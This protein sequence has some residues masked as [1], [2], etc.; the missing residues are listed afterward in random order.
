MTSKCAG[1]LQNLP[2][3]E[4]LTCSLCKSSYDLDCANV[5]IVRFNNTMSAEHK[6]N[7]KCQACY[8]KMPK[9]GNTNTPVRIQNGPQPQRSPNAG[10]N[11]TMRRK[12]TTS[13]YDTTMVYDD[14][15]SIL[16]NTCMENNS[17]NNSCQIDSLLLT[18]IE[19]LLEKKL[20]NNK[21]TLLSELKTMLIQEISASVT[22]EIALNINTISTEQHTM[23]T[24]INQLNTQIKSL[25]I[26]TNRLQI[27]INELQ[28]KMTLQTNEQ[29][30]WLYNFENNRKFV[31]YG[32]NE[33]YWETE[34]ELHNRVTYIF[35]DLL[36]I[37]LEDYIESIHRLGK[38][39]N[40]RPLVIELMSKKMVH[41]ILE[42][43]LY[44]RN[45]GLAISEHLDET[46]RQ[47]RKKLTNLMHEA[48]K[49]G[50]H[51]I[52][53]NNKLLING[54]EYNHTNNDET[55]SEVN[56]ASKISNTESE[57]INQREY[58]RRPKNKNKGNYN[59]REHRNIY[60]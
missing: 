52:L 15:E 18:Q 7:W 46:S 38:R 23:K 32:L 20:E 21:K 10:A 51:A 48:R 28:Q 8:C 12:P 31:L 34:N 14:D 42:N 47:L 6:R 45:T 19:E 41:Y 39:G 1:C 22:N 2:R 17:E 57:K 33:N 53:R 9:T 37:N 60:F 25:Q 56:D 24:E 3:R 26:E 59:F 5:P 40:R 29:T 58:D 4:F 27:Q 43:R 44:F 30:E 11:V 13:S 36:N 49:N 54:K 55:R 16:G 50:H 35:Q